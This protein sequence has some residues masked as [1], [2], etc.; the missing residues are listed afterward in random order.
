MNTVSEMFASGVARD[1][2]VE[3]VAADACRI[4]EDASVSTASVEVLRSL[5]LQCA[6]ASDAVNKLM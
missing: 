6:N 4:L 2:K 5:L 3:Q 1:M